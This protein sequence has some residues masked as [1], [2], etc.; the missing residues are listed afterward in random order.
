MHRAVMSS[1]VETTISGLDKAKLWSAAVIVAVAVA[2]FYYFS[3][4]SLLVRVLGLLLAATA[5]GAI[6][7]QT[8]K[9]RLFAAFIKEAQ[10]EVRKVVWPTREETIKTTT[11]VVVVVILVAIALWLLD[12]LLGW[13]VRSLTAMGVG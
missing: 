7:Y 2:S 11:A 8:E 9:G 1:K 5:A 12:L 3:E 13:V 6:G 10:I 4:H